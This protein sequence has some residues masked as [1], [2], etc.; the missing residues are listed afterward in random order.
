MLVNQDHFLKEF[1]NI[2]KEKLTTKQ[3][4]GLSPKFLY[5]CSRFPSAYF[6]A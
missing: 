6:E 3:K 2:R 5:E 1:L 4:C